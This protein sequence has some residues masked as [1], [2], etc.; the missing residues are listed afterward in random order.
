MYFFALFPYRICADSNISFKNETLLIFYYIPYKIRLKIIFVASWVNAIKSALLC[1]LHVASNGRVH[2]MHKNK[3]HKFYNDNSL[4]F[5]FHSSFNEVISRKSQSIKKN[6]KIMANI[7]FGYGK[8]STTINY[9]RQMPFNLKLLIDSKRAIRFKWCISSGSI[10][11]SL[12][13]TTFA[14]TCEETCYEDLFLCA[15]KIGSYYLKKMDRHSIFIWF[16]FRLE[17]LS[18]II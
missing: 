18:I 15:I 17:K 13:K 8:M 6:W 5:L 3:P 1:S 7:W 10:D 2:T 16:N 12:K 4:W 11:F 9:C 14:N